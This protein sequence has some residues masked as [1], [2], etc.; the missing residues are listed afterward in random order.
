MFPVEFV[1][2]PVSAGT[3]LHGAVVF[4]TGGKT[5]QRP[6]FLPVP[7]YV[8][9]DNA[10]KK[11]ARNS[12]AVKFGSS[13]SLNPSLQEQVMEDG[14]LLEFLPLAPMAGDEILAS[15]DGQPL[16]ILRGKGAESVHLVGALPLPLLE[17]DYLWKHFRAG[18]FI[19]VL[20]LIVFLRQLTR[21]SDWQYPG[22]RACF[23]LDDPSL[24]WPSYGHLNYRRLAEHSRAHDYFVS[25]ATIPLDTWWLNPKVL[26][27]FRA[28][29]PRL[30]LLLHGN[31]HLQQELASPRSPEQIVRLLAQALR[32]FERLE[33]CG[34]LEVCR[35]MEAPHGAFAKALLEGLRSFD[36]EGVMATADLLA[37]YNPNIRWSSTLG[38]EAVDLMT[39]VG[40]PGIPRIVMTKD[41]KSGVLLA[42]ILDQPLVA[43]GHH[44]DAADGMERMAQYAQLVNGI[45]GVTWATPAGILR[46]NYKQLRQGRA[47]HVQLCS[48]R[49]HLSIPEGVEELW[50]HRP[51]LDPGDGGEDL[52]V[53]CGHAPRSASLPAG[54]GVCGPFPVKQMENLVVACSLK[55]GVDF[56]TIAPPPASLRPIVRKILVELRDRCSPLVGWKNEYE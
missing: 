38:L 31:D 29:A 54:N 16:W 30:S 46:S 45:G 18:C 37:R 56:K 36:V 49:I 20:P 48:R 3:V 27:V 5:D 15:S 14:D 39:E 12:P 26:A 9:A 44:S 4:D 2:G 19:R 17:N 6:G 21:E 40:L 10:A 35:V 1:P 24:Y 50:I 53:Q 41:W 11:V 34:G 23:V 8:A 43:A 7:T 42:G 32:R 33:R 55:N 22:R 13:G 47:L 25:V 51:W 28:N 52:T